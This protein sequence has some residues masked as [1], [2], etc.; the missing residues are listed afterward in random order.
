MERYEVGKTTTGS[1]LNQPSLKKGELKN[2]TERNS[3]NTLKMNQKLEPLVGG[4]DFE[5]RR[6]IHF[7]RVFFTQADVIQKNITQNFSAATRKITVFKEIQP[8][9]KGKLKELGAFVLHYCLLLCL[10]PTKCSEW[11]TTK[12][13][14]IIKNYIIKLWQVKRNK[15]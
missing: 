8:Q 1:F 4:N 10:F 15:Q 9:E 12:S 7:G 2:A 6:R 14:C 11:Y 13:K 5:G 3:K